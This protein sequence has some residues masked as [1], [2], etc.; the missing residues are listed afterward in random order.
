MIV[1]VSF[2]FLLIFLFILF[3]PFKFIIENKHGYLDIN[4]SR[5]FIYRIYLEPLLTPN[6]D[7]ASSEQRKILHL[8]KSSKLKYLYINLDG[9]NFDYEI[10]GQYYGLIH[11]L[12]SFERTI[13]ASQDVIF[14]YNVRYT[15][16]KSFRFK[17]IL[18]VKLATIIKDKIIRRKKTNER[19]SN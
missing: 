1:I 16:D 4:F 11:V 15:D 8:I 2:I 5:L 3:F 13:L 14:N 19:T 17:S 12:F 7:K 6:D 10:G 18:R 9:L